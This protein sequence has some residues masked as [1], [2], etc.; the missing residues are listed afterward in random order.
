L[1]N[2]LAAIL[3]NYF[4]L[5]QRIPF[6]IYV[7]YLHF[8]DLKSRAI[9][10]TIKAGVS[11]IALITIYVLSGLVLKVPFSEWVPISWG[12]PGLVTWGIFFMIY[13][14]ACLRIAFN[15]ITAF[16]FAT[17]ATFG[18][19]WLYEICFFHPWKMLV[20]NNTIFLFNGQILYLI[21]L[22]YELKKKGFKPNRNVYLAFGIFLFFSL[23]LFLDFYGVA[24]LFK[25]R[26]GSRA[27]AWFY[28][29][30]ACN[31]LISLLGGIKQ[32]EAKS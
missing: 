19:G 28:R 23:N 13:Y 24:Y 7:F 30:P 31:F 32:I 6:F 4:Y 8:K 11:F 16:T 18:G 27:F 17:L 3:N 15:D 20:S 25:I 9:S 10:R 1:K 21:L 14:F 2:P 5:R 29:I 26:W 22:G 12:Y